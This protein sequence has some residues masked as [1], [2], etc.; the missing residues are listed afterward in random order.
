MCVV[1][2]G[3]SGWWYWLLARYKSIPTQDHTHQVQNC[4]ADVDCDMGGGDSIVYN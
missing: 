1:M 4:C 2:D 3:E